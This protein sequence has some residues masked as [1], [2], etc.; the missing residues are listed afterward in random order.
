MLT[1]A[2]QLLVC[3]DGSSAVEL[4][5]I[6]SAFLSMLFG[7]VNVAM[8]LWTMASLHYAAESA[9]RCAAVGSSGC[10]N[11]SSIQTYALNQ[12]SGPSLGTNPNPFSYSATGCGNTVAADYNYSLVIPMI[13]SFPVPL[14][15]TACSP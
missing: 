8:M 2:R 7:I 4:A 1:R 5:V 3:E 15:T 6:M 10:T 13:R 9:A 11:A 12:Y 14:S